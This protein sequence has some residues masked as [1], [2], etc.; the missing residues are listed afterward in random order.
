MSDVQDPVR[1]LHSLSK[2]FH[3]KLKP[4]LAIGNVRMHS[5]VVVKTVLAI[6]GR[7]GSSARHSSASACYWISGNEFRWAAFATDR[8][9]ENLAHCWY[10]GRAWT[11]AFGL[12]TAV[13]QLLEAPADGER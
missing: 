7:I 4:C 3:A 12:A 5:P 11:G 6:A 13:W 8:L 10:L 9:L 1:H 2:R